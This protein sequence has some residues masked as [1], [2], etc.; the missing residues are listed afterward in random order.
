M[1]ALSRSFW[2]ISSN[3][4]TTILA[5]GQAPTSDRQDTCA[6][7][8]SQ[9][10]VMMDHPS[11]IIRSQGLG[12]GVGRPRG[13]GIDRGVGVGLGVAVG[14]GVGVTVGVTVAVGV[15]V[16]VCVAVGVGVGPC[17]PGNTRT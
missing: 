5:V 11:L 13:V 3:P 4:S 12:L 14:V 2:R 7:L 9:D 16:G 10:P 17:P 15:G 1:A 8:R 6:T